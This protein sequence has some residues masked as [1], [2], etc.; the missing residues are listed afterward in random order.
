MQIAPP[1]KMDQ[2]GIG[3]ATLSSGEDRCAN[4]GKIDGGRSRRRALRDRL[5]LSECAEGEALA[6]AFVLEHRPQGQA[7]VRYV[8]GRHA[9]QQPIILGG[10]SANGLDHFHERLADDGQAISPGALVPRPLLS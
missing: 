4:G 3:Y 9:A 10:L 6:F 7:F 5:F 1:S 2:F 8:E